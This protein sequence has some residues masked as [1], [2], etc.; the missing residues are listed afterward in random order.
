MYVHACMYVCDLCM[1]VMYVCM[2]VCMYMFPHFFRYLKYMKQNGLH[3]PK[4]IKI[5]LI[6]HDSMYHFSTIKWNR[7]FKSLEGRSYQKWESQNGADW[8]GDWNCT[9]LERWKMHFSRC[10]SLFSAMKREKQR[11]TK[12]LITIH[13]EALYFLP[14]R[15][16]QISVYV[17]LLQTLGRFLTTRAW[18]GVGMLSSISWK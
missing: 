13:W 4:L 15:C 8:G 2:H 1:Y 5:T 12:C 9:I 7:V 14:N 6:R 11:K 17:F 3:R 18:E 16:L 10:L